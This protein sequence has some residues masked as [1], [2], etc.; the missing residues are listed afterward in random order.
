MEPFFGQVVSSGNIGT[1]GTGILRASNRR[2]RLDTA[3]TTAFSRPIMSMDMHTVPTPTT[4]APVSASASI[5]RV[6][7]ATTG[8]AF[9]PP[10]S[11]VVRPPSSEPEEDLHLSDGEDY[12]S[13][14]H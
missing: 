13:N 2:R 11:I 1:F 14:C 10:S 12:H 5:A 6:L 4:R 8:R 9:P 3:V 7:S